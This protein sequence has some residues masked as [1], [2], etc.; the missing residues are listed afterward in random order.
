MEDSSTDQAWLRRA[1]ETKRDGGA[2]APAVW[3]RIIAGYVG[4]AID[5]APVA[6]LAM[7]CTIRGMDDDEIFALTGAM[8][9]SGDVLAFPAGPTVVDK[10]SSGG[11]GDTISLV[12]VPLV[13]ACGVPVAKLS[14][15][16]LGH[17]GGTLDKLEA[18]PGVRTGLTPD[19]FR[20]QIERI[21]CAIAA[22]SERLVP[23]DKRLYALRD[24]TGSVPSI[25]LIAASIVSKKIAGGAG[26]IVFDVKCGRGAFM[27]TTRDAVALA[28]TMVR[29]AERFGRPSSAIVTDMDEP[30]AA[31]IGT[32]LEAIEARDFLR[33]SAAGSRFARLT[34]IVAQ[35]MLRVGGVPEAEIEPRLDAALRG[36]AAYERFVALVEAQGGRRAGFEGMAAASPL[37]PVRAARDGYVEAID[38][39]AI[40]EAARD[41]VGRHGPFAG[42]RI[43][44]PVGTRV[45]A[46]EPLAFVAGGMDT[47]GAVAGAFSLSSEAPAKRALVDAIIRD[48]SSASSSNRAES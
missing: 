10:H 46:G 32:G 45:A 43:A 48:A 36:G 6:A 13:A 20:A 38:P 39:I 18:I 25:G 44:A 24:R 33:G 19:A 23:A 27:R 12:V 2:L 47:D 9:D 31:E 1:I 3:R 21:G 16:A 29:L 7:A 14:G 11:V 8:V 17:T 40:G 5:D 4:G 15:R 37:T 30:L 42:V 41:L 22:Q 34:A 35:E 28:T 26:A